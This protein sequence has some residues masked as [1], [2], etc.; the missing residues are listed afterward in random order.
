MSVTIGDLANALQAEAWGDL[1]LRVTGAGEPAQVDPVGSEG[2]LIAM[3]MAPKYAEA[4]KP[5]SIAILAV[6]MDPAA[7]GL[8]A[9]I[10]AP[11]PRLVMAGLTRAF[12]KGPQIQLGIHPSAVID[13]SAVI[14]ENAAIGPLVVIGPNVRI[15][16][17]AR[18]ASHVSI[19]RDTVIGDDALLHP[20]VRVAHEVRAGDRLILQPNASIGG[21][22][23][24]FVTPEESG[25]EDIRRTLGSPSNTGPGSIPLAASR[26]ATMSRSARIPALTVAP[27]APPASDPAARSTAL[28]RS[29][30]MSSSAKI[31]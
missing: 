4:L 20:G 11:R 27:S 7:Y 14:G 16:R 2:G 8:R 15:G 18:I 5:G 26:S 24:S 30:T 13:P 25:I 3:A 31:A 1:S 23:F 21:D 22:G 10:F 29:A 9:A 12:D 28:F 19:G 17:N 6:G